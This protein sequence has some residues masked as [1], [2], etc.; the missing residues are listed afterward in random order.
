M[1]FQSAAN[2]AE[3]LQDLRITLSDGTTTITLSEQLVW[4][5]ELSWSPVSQ[6]VQTSLTGALIVYAAARTAGRPITLTRDRDTRAWLTR[7]VL[8]QCQAW[9]ATAGQALTLTLRGTAYAV[10]WRHQ[11]GAI[12]ASAVMP[13][14]DVDAADFYRA[15]LRYLEQSGAADDLVLLTVKCKKC[16]GH[17]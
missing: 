8:D 7:A 9:A 3:R 15:T 5:D 1:N 13:W 10:L 4:T 12:E 14:A 6:A 11:D 17:L 16:P 2:P